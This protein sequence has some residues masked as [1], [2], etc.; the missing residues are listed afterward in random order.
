MFIRYKD[1]KQLFNASLDAIVRIDNEDRVVEINDSFVNLFKYSRE[2][3]VGYFLDDFIVNDEDKSE[4]Y[5]FNRKV[6]DG[7]IFNFEAERIDKYGNEHHVVI[8]GI[9]IID[10]NEMMGSFV[11]YKDTTSEV[12]SS[13]NLVK[14]KRTLE[15]LF[16]NSNDAIV[17]IDVEQ[18]VLDIN[19]RFE[20]L[21]GYS[22]E[23]IKGL[24]VDQLITKPSRL[25]ESV[26]LTNELL[27]GKKIVVEGIRYD[28]Y[29]NPGMY[30]VQGV[31]II[32]EDVVI[33]GYGIYTDI[34][35]NKKAEEE[36]NHQNVIFEAL[37][38]N[39]S[40][41]IVRFDEEHK[42][43]DINENFTELFGYKI[44]EIKN[45]RIDD[46]IYVD[47]DKDAAV[48]L[49][50]LLLDGEKFMLEG[51]RRGK[52]NKM[53][54]VSIKGV[55]ITTGDKTIGGYG[56]YAD[57]S[58]RKK[59]EKEILY[60]SYHDQLTGVY[61]RRFFEEEFKRLNTSRS[62]PI[63]LIMADVNG[64]KLINDAFGHEAGD[65]LLKGMAGVLNSCCRQGEI[66]SRLGGDEFVILLP[67]TDEYEAEKIVKRIKSACH[68]EEFKNIEFSMSFG[69]GSKDT[70][71]ESITTLFK[72]VEDLM[73]KNKL[74]E[75]P[76]IRG[77]MFDTVIKTL[78]AKNE[79]EERHS[80]RVSDYC[81]RVA[82]SLCM[83][84]IKVKELKT[85]GWLHD[86]GK[87]AI[88][89]SILDKPG[90]LT[91][92]EWAEIKKHPEIG[93]RILN[94]INE[95]TELSEHILSHHERYDGKGYPKGLKGDEIPV[96]SRIIAI[97]D[98]YDAMTSDRTYRKALSIDEAIQQLKKN[99][100]T[101][102]DPL[103][104]NVFIEILEIEILEIEELK[105]IPS[106]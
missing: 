11:I 73:Y 38:K 3:M 53:V 56:I 102:F 64:L 74:V 6:A 55:P 65:E 82:K 29:Q 57:I 61:N 32:A 4:A 46:V 98:A 89:D 47:G 100:G 5:Q 87:I 34:S 67:N 86:I 85:A 15:S 90:K 84:S 41:A 27:E 16:K 45:K 39:S 7:K 106:L 66:I 68:N 51:I 18:R 20:Y 62:L 30:I 104:V 24:K 92:S 33:G 81:A 69:W 63:S 35:E 40:D 75:S 28:K 58:A 43:L 12:H 54:D 99:S 22:L 76:S 50:N 19:E 60:M 103:L 21:F 49:T 1:Y 31:P 8:M 97:A 79:R 105:L 52:N 96:Q 42:V 78:H 14:Q 44:E 91:E 88:S 10:D 101:Q 70:V 94:S 36:R 72:R 48:Q 95:F 26:S 13:I 77:R 80:S 25:D 2:E 23:E 17:H 9:P 37:F 93:Y 71:E 83:N 59:A